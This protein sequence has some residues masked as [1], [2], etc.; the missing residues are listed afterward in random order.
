MGKIVGLKT[1]KKIKT[2]KVEKP[3]EKTV[4]KPVM[5]TEK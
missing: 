1:I 3:I 5:K 2:V 4:E